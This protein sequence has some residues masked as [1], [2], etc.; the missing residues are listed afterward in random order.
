[1][2]GKIYLNVKEFKDPDE[3]ETNANVPKSIYIFPNPHIN[4]YYISICSLTHF[5]N[6]RLY[7]LIADF[8]KFSILSNYSKVLSL[9][10]CYCW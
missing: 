1:M 10:N 6:T 5:T 3:K 9:P 2:K 8:Q 7:D 4:M